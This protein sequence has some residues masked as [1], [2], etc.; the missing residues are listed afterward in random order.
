MNILKLFTLPF[1]L[2]LLSFSSYADDCIF[3]TGDVD[4]NEEL[5]NQCKENISKTNIIV[6]KAKEALTGDKVGSIYE[7]LEAMKNGSVYLLNSGDKFT[8]IV[9][10][11]VAEFLYNMQPLFY[12]FVFVAVIFVAKIVFSF[13]DNREELAIKSKE[14]GFKILSSVGVV[15]IYLV[16]ASIVV[17]LAIQSV[18]EFSY[19]AVSAY[20]KFAESADNI[21]SF[22][23][24]TSTP[25]SEFINGVLKTAYFEYKTE[26]DFAYS[27]S[28]DARNVFK[29][30]EFTKCLTEKMAFDE[31]LKGY[32][33]SK[34]LQVLRLCS[35]ELEGTQ[36]ISSGIIS[37]DEQSSHIADTMDDL[38]SLLLDFAY[39]LDT[40]TCN[41]TERINKDFTDFV[42]GKN[43]SDYNPY[44][45]KFSING[46]GKAVL[47]GKSVS[48]DELVSS[49][50]QIES[51]IKNSNKTAAIEAAGKIEIKPMNVTFFDIV[52]I[53]INEH[54]T[55][56][57]L[58]EAAS[59]VLN[60]K[61]SYIGTIQFS[62]A[63][64]QFKKEELV[65]KGG[66]KTLQ[67]SLRSFQVIDEYTNKTKIDALNNIKYTLAENIGGGYLSS[68]GINKYKDR[69]F[70]ILSSMYYS[71]KVLS[72]QTLMTSIGL[73]FIKK[74]LEPF[75]TK[76]DSE[77]PN[78]VMITAEK[79][80]GFL[81]QAHIAIFCVV[82][83]V[84]IVLLFEPI[85][86]FVLDCKAFC[87]TVLRAYTTIPFM[88]AI[89]VWKNEGGWIDS[90]LERLAVLVYVFLDL[91]F[92]IFK[93]IMIFVVL[94]IVTVQFDD[95]FIMLQDNLSMF[96]MDNNSI[97]GI[98]GSIVLAGIVVILQAWMGAKTITVVFQ[99]MDT[100]KS[101]YAF[102]S[103]SSMNYNMNGR[104]E[105]NAWN[106]Y[107]KK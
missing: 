27:K 31:N 16:I 6:N 86:Y 20:K 92:L 25:D 101:I 79:I 32:W 1:F 35:L 62:Q 82:F 70:N 88:I 61:S 69:D 21:A 40:Y 36:D 100:I 102:G 99:Q 45:K 18:E 85:K 91:F 28:F 50:Q 24:N 29:E 60:Y 54:E 90:V 44:T 48:Y 64:A 30:D 107:M 93:F 34:E 63:E 72:Q 77:I 47:T 65:E 67:Q 52:V 94:Y 98:L 5:S 78:S 4:Y 97:S 96:G 23:D 19:K 9:T 84:C 13:K 49:I 22:I 71:A 7:L 81:S 46:N 83:P 17:I 89:D 41:K 53:L 26:K 12:I 37:F 55:V 76:S 74:M 3:Y 103:G 14:F 10:H 33:N 8:D 42:D 51:V 80:I 2:M 104:V 59:S 106:S 66:A 38:N 105:K 57:K 75:G 11:A 68:I 95:I 43:C 58:K 73:K 39:K 56:A 15:S 87:L